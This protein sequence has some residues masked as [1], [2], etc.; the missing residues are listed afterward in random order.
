M[1]CTAELQGAVFDLDG[2][3]TQTAK[4]HFRAWKETF[5]AIIAERKGDD[6]EPFTHDEDYI[7]YVDGKPRYQGVK[8][9]LES[10]DISLPFGTPED[11][12]GS[13]TICA[14][15]NRK[16]ERFRELVAE[17][18]VEV[19]DS[20][21]RLID[22][23]LAGDVKVAVASSSRNATYIM[24]QTGIKEKF[25]AIVDGNV[26]RKLD[27]SGKPDPDIFLLA[28]ERI[29]TSP[30]E[31]MMVEDA[32][33]GVEAGRNGGFGLVLGVARGADRDRLF[34]YG[35]DI[36]V[37][38][39]GEITREDIDHWFAE[40]L[41]N[42]CWM[43]GYHGFHDEDERL[44]EALTTVGNGYFG[45]RG[46]L[47]SEGIDDNTHNP[48]TYIA[49]LFDCAETEIRGR[50]IS[51]NDFVNCP[52]WT[53]TTVHVDDGAALSPHSCEVVSYRHW[54]EFR[55]ATMHHDLTLRDQEGRITR[56]QS[57]RFASMDR[58]HLAA[59]RMT[60][61]AEN[62]SSPVTIRATIDGDVR[63][64]LVER[65]RDLAQRHLEPVGESGVAEERDD[66]AYLEMRTV[67]SRHSVC[68]RSRTSAALGGEGGRSGE[69]T[70]VQR[71]FESTVD[72]V[73]EEFETDLEEHESVTIEKLVAIYTGKDFDTDDPRA[74]AE[75]L[76]NDADTY[77]IER[78]R[79][80]ER[81]AELWEDADIVV[82][83]DRFAQR[84]LR[85]HAYH[86]LSTASPNNTRLD[87][88][89]PARGLHGEAYRGHIFWDETFIIPFF[90]LRFPDIAKSHLMYRY[91]RLDAARELAKEAGY[92]GA[93]YPWQSA[94]TGGPES[95]ELHYNPRSGEWDPDL[96]NLQRHISISIAY[97]VYTYFYTTGDEGF[98]H[99][100]GMEML[101]EIGRF[102]ASIAEFEEADGRYH[103]R[104]V[105]GPDEFHE[106]YPDASY[107][108]GGLDDNAYTN[109]MAAWLLHKIAETYEHLP[110]DAKA[111]MRERIHIDQREISDWAEIV[112]RMNVVINDD[113]IISQFDGYMDLDEL[114]WE[115]YRRKYDNIR[116]MDRILKAENDSPDG[117]KVSKQA[118]VLMMF[119]L[120]APDQ[121][122]H[123][124]GMMGY[125]DVSGKELLRRNYEYY[126]QRTSHGSTL[127]WIVHSA[128]LRYLDEHKND[129]WR[130]FVECLRSDVFDTQ[131]GTTL[132]G[133]HCGVMA[134]SI[135]IVVS[136]FAGVNLFRDHIELDPYLPDGWRRV[137]FVI[138]QRA[139]RLRIEVE[140][141]EGRSVAYLTRMA[142]A[143]LDL[144]ARCRGKEF[145]L[146]PEKRVRISV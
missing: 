67:N 112:T 63:N 45:T 24:E 32:Y 59:M 60:V 88:G 140:L 51:N 85:F 15:G 6:V 47:E 46:S 19:F 10:R 119:Y 100:Y 122:K 111:R 37:S 3:V 64:F 134:G 114:D 86:L 56:I 35:A 27:L 97:D 22:E 38:D 133:I 137:S 17:G 30:V 95:Q 72:R 96:S 146:P 99:D 58:P 121:V 28:A 73:T 61:T 131:G 93:M 83:G 129:Q 44:R 102:W 12:P 11:E 62:H 107:D 52:N 143:G 7:P 130:W 20:S 34:H 115:E 21:I 125:D 127:S 57:E 124:L 8:S 65:Y 75:E 128:I 90:T 92:R 136:A 53:A 9:F 139:E 49:G 94:D 135:D 142:T 110:E 40:R 18:G 5:D 87:V 101:L 70:T 41:P 29:G 82:E 42:D 4:L 68:M 144:T 1:S 54:V 116:R 36:V 104:G 91:R 39:L 109:V 48:G 113:K 2:V 123:I 26:S 66:G 117:Y 16:N 69:G 77:D 126:V 145:R 43:L 84:I 55:S 138:Q 80:V 118:D 33:A 81:W 108:E 103:I 25:G 79:H 120:L 98:L 71:S 89:L 74:A 50:T 105:M 78:S 23:L 14:I 141:E 31:T 132:E 106:K 76:A 13:E